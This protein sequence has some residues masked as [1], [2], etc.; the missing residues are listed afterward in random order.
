[1][2]DVNLSMVSA[3]CETIDSAIDRF[4]DVKTKMIEAFTLLD[5][6]HLRFG[7]INSSLSSQLEELADQTIKCSVMNDGITSTIR[8]NAQRQH[9]QYLSW[10]ES[11]KQQDNSGKEV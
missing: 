4:S 6:N 3:G 2:Q 5:Q 1:M 8:E 7:D 9:E 11:L 10:L